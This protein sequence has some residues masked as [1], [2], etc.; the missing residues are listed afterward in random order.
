MWYSVSDTAEY[1]GLTRGSKVISEPARHAMAK[2]LADIQS[3]EF[4]KEWIA[5]DDAG[6]PNFNRL[7]NEARTNLIE[8]TGRPLRRMMSWLDAETDHAGESGWSPRDNT[9]A[10]GSGGSSPRDNTA[11]ENA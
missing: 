4:A 10:G 8:Q 11:E 6:R 7:R 9:A 2:I 1:G 3:G 5:E